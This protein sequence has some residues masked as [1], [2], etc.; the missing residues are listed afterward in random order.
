MYGVHISHPSKIAPRLIRQARAN[1]FNRPGFTLV[2]L[3]VVISIIALLISILLPSLVRARHD[4]LRIV[5]SSNLRTLG[6]GCR[7]YAGNFRGTMPTGAP[8]TQWA[9]GNWA[10]GGLDGWHTPGNFGVNYFTPW[11]LG[12]LYSTK[13]I[14]NGTVFYCP[15]GTYFTPT[16]HPEI[17]IGN[18]GKPNG[19]PNY[20]YVFLGYCYY[21]GLSEG[22][23]NGDG[24][25]NPMTRSTV[26]NPTTLQPELS[27][28]SVPNGF[29]QSPISGDNTIL[30]SD[31]TVSSG[32]T[33][34]YFSNHFNGGDHDVTGGNVLYND[35]H[36]VWK[37]ASEMRCRLLDAGLYFWQ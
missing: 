36:V 23:N 31:I 26:I 1:G 17:C 18:L 19:P 9:K 35:G 24:T 34:Y 32:E 21:Y 6:Q 22:S 8:Q 27:F 29:A 2:E 12:L 3:L 33:W 28:A 13:T 11:G 15:E 20:E 25:F 10:F 16:A 37:N 4:A 5:C 14:T 30:A 7:V